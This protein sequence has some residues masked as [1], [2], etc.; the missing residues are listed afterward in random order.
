MGCPRRP[1]AVFALIA[2]VVLAS[3]WPG[4]ARQDDPRLDPLFAQLQATP[5][6][7]EGET[8]VER[9]WTI[10]L[11]SGAEKIDGLM[12]VGVLAMTQ[13]DLN[14]ALAAFDEM[15]AL[16]PDFAEAWN[17]RATV[18]Y[19]RGDYDA[20]LADVEKTLALEPRHFGALAG[21]GLIHLANGDERRALA[22]FER[23]L[24]VNPHMKPIEMRVRE[25]RERVRGKPI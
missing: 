25:L 22:A 23:G 2:G 16:A 19:M 13:H 14:S 4:F 17:K 6:G 21:L 12:A 9:I 1:L 3:A 5:D 15:V 8:I 20:S 18:H 11:Q 7:G 10:W 24:R